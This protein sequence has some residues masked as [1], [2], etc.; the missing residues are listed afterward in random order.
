MELGT[1]GDSEAM[2][3]GDQSQAQTVGVT[4][5]PPPSP[6]PAGLAWAPGRGLGPAWNSGACLHTQGPGPASR[7]SLPSLW[8]F[9][10]R[11]GKLRPKGARVS[12][13]G[14]AERRGAWGHHL[15]VPHHRPPQALPGCAS[16]HV[17][18][19][20]QSASVAEASVSPCVP[21]EPADI[22][23]RGRCRTNAPNSMHCDSRPRATGPTGA[24]ALP[25][26]RRGDEATQSALCRLRPQL[27]R[28]QTTWPWAGVT[29]DPRLSFPV[30]STDTVP[31]GLWL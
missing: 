19:I 9:S 5:R 1:S 23:G 14:V 26:R 6:L 30:Y 3:C 13:A 22:P 10:L 8:G 4:G 16:R 29:L 15:H 12:Q 27:C 25:P 18:Q 17:W 2:A 21:N 28:L 20:R 31:R 7:V 11:M 24:P